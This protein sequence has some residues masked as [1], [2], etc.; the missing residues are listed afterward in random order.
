MKTT[1]KS[2]K[3]QS[4]GINEETR[5]EKLHTVTFEN[6]QEAS[7]LIARE[8]CDLIRSKQEKNKNCVIGFATGS[9][10]T[11]VYQEIIRIHKEESLSFN[12][13][14]AF[15]LDE[16]FPIK[17]DDKNSYHQFMNENL[18]DHIDI[19]KENINIPSGEIKKRKIEYLYN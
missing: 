9:S 6:S 15:N 4:P 14:I 19:P 10:P 7:I 1:K 18:F 12:N 2:L 11:K 17:K 3:Y 16:Y 5:Y 13:V 8:I